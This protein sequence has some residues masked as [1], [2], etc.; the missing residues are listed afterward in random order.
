MEWW[1]SFQHW[2][3]IALTLCVV[4]TCILGIVVWRL[5]AD[6][7][8]M[9]G[10]VVL[11]LHGQFDPER[12][13]GLERGFSGFANKGVF[14]VAVLYVVADGLHRTGAFRWLGM[15]LLGNPSG[16]MSA[17][18]RTMIPTALLSSFL[19]NT[20]VVAL[21]MPIIN[22]WSR[23][24]RI[25]VSHLLLPLSYAAILGGM[26]TVI[27]TSTTIVI[28]SKLPAEQQL[29]M[30][31]LTPIGLAVT[32]AG[33]AMIALC[34]RWLLPERKPAFTQMD[35]PRE[36]SVEMEIDP[37]SPLV[38]R[39]I[40]EAGL[41]QL[42]GMYLMEIDRGGDVLPAVAS[43]TRLQANDHLVF[44]GVVES[45]VD[46]QRIPGL[47]PATDQL[48]K[49]DGPR[50]HRC[51]VEAVVSSSYPYLRM[52][53]R[54]SRFRANYNAAIIA[55]SRDGVRLKG[56]IGDMRLQA[57]DTLLLESHA[58]FIEQQR[59]SRHFFLV[60]EVQDSAPV[61]HEKASLARMIMLAMIAVVT[62]EWLDM[63]LAASIAA[64][65]MVV[66]RCTRWSEAR[67]GIEWNVILVMGAGLGIGEAMTTSGTAEL[68]TSRISA[69]VGG[70]PWMMLVA[71]YV[72]AV[73]LTNLITAKAAAGLMVP[74]VGSAAA[75]FHVSPIPFAIAL[76][77]GAAGSFV[78]PYGYQTNM[79]VYGPGGY[80]SSDY[81]RLG[82]PL[83]VVVGLVTVILTPL[84]WP[85][86]PLEPVVEQVLE[87]R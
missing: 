82:L 86:V 75:S 8:L 4:V 27:G 59:N 34:T 72:V 15:Q 24:H 10:L 30:F 39:T 33:I 42:P 1:E 5:P 6:F 19:N 81:V 40:E 77:M 60:S 87:P 36:Y 55:V 20:P 26:C 64:F 53:V 57:G 32:I 17:Q 70:S 69:L 51:L 79:M 37:S 14:A 43:D 74:I 29:S 38:G 9:F 47:K 45:V 85:L 83:T 80:R 52:T 28:N 3:P 35:D 11:L 73:V 49:L 66:T 2:L 67:R 16:P 13:L 56:K 7:T 46:L 65:L 23:R 61:Q 78:T 41:R 58:N 76:I 84:W 22:D 12:G 63:S 54:E 62:M 31:E 50:S 44:V 25:S 48:F 18:L 68:M 21:M 71:I